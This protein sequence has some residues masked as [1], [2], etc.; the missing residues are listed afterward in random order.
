MDVK[1][2][3]MDVGVPSGPRDDPEVLTLTP[4]LLNVLNPFDLL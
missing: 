1:D 3:L 2:V 4:Q